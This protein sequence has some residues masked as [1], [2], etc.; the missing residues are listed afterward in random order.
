MS[1]S[2]VIT[3]DV[4]PLTSGRKLK[5]RE[6]LRQWLICSPRSEKPC[7]IDLPGLGNLNREAGTDRQENEN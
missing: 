2:R 1:E 5:V 7:S 6:I 3:D 4:L